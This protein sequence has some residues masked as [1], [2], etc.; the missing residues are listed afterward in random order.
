MKLIKNRKGEVSGTA[1][2][3]VFIGTF[4]AVFGY[5]VNTMPLSLGT[6]SQYQSSYPAEL[7][8]GIDVTNFYA[9]YN[10]STV[11]ASGGN[12]L[13]G[14]DEF[15]H[16]LQTSWYDEIP[17]VSP[18]YIDMNHLDGFFLFPHNMEVKSGAN[19]R[20]VELDLDEIV[21]DHDE[22]NM[23]SYEVYCDHLTMK[24]WV[25]YNTTTYSSIYDAWDSDEVALLYAID[26]DQ[27]G[28]SWNG[29]S[30][31]AQFLT[32][33]APEVN[34]VINYFIAIPIWIS[35]AVLIVLVISLIL[36]F[37]G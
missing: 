32:F 23:S 35:I 6:G 18:S 29:W 36:P 3:I 9:Y 4:L 13:W 27:A 30:L 14:K 28:T 12:E 31:I 26:F 24:M 1:G 20:G 7:F 15:G 16:D 2:A 10:F 8:H 11:G 34:P 22:N 33:Q 25:S 21:L 19:Y 17:G 5:M 37:V